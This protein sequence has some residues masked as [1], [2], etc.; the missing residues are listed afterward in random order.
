MNRTIRNQH[1]TASSWSADIF[2]GH[3]ATHRL[4]YRQDAESRLWAVTAREVATGRVIAKM[5]DPQQ[6]SRDAIQAWVQTV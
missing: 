6:I 4:V 3:T 5:T 1:G 2:T